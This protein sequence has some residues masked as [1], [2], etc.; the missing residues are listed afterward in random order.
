[1]SDRTFVEVSRRRIVQEVADALRN[2]E[3]ATRPGGV[4]ARE[5]VVALAIGEETEDG[6]R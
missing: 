6:Q 5:R 4:G 3:P 2:E 1:M